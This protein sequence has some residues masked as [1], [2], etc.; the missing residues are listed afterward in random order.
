MFKKTKVTYLVFSIPIIAVLIVCITLIVLNLTPKNYQI[1]AIK[2]TSIFTEHK[3]EQD[4]Y[5]Y[6]SRSNPWFLSTSKIKKIYL[7]DK[8]SNKTLETKHLETRY[9]G[10]EEITKNGEKHKY[11]QNILTVSAVNEFKENISFSSAVLEISFKN[12]KTLFLDIGLV[13][14]IKSSL[15]A[16]PFAL[17]YS[18]SVTYDSTLF[19]DRP[20]Y[21]LKLYS[22]SFSL[23]KEYGEKVKDIKMLLNNSDY[24]FEKEEKN[25][26]IYFELKQNIGFPNLWQTYRPFVLIYV[27]TE[28]GVKIMRQ[29]DLLISSF[30]QVNDLLNKAKN[31][32]L[33]YSTSFKIWRN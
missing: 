23:L 31:S 6:S 22:L 18:V 13:Q 14:V 3:N 19:A 25:G 28:D 1:K 33:V 16:K 5:L 26:R 10:L 11:F 15:I 8:N 12:N 24:S 21:Q 4:F 20:D 17:N 27:D 30:T 2:Q 29:N 7:K 32:K 9:K